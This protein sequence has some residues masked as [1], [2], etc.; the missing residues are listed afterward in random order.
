MAVM[1]GAFDEVSSGRQHLLYRTL[2]TTT[3]AFPYSIIYV[4]DNGS[5]GEDAA[6][7]ER[8]VQSFPGVMYRNVGVGKDGNRTAGRLANKRLRIL[9]EEQQTPKGSLPSAV[10][11]CDDDVW[12][13]PGAEARLENVWRATSPDVSRRYGIIGG[14]LEPVWSWNQ[15]ID[16]S[17]I[18]V[19]PGVVERVL[20]R[21]NAPG[22]ALSL[23]LGRSPEE[24]GWFRRW[25]DGGPPAFEETM[26]WDIAVCKR[27][28]DAG[29]LVGQMDLCDNTGVSA[30]GWENNAIESAVPL[31][32]EAWGL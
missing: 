1:I 29:M 9:A 6:L 22:C 24:V 16:V 7:V 19:R 11:L 21:P 20:T 4:V 26:H 23:L 10:V 8:M 32:R 25:I 17:V 13:Y 27:V 30:S 2:K 14:Y 28:T 12:W 5:T 3:S 31:D 18:E 15:P